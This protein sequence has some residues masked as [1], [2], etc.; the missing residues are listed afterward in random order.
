MI[1]NLYFKEYI[2]INIDDLFQSNIPKILL[3]KDNKLTNKT[4]KTF[5]DIFD[6]FSIDE[7]RIQLNVHNLLA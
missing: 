7:K 5:K 1:N 4:I 6:L 2:R 3:I